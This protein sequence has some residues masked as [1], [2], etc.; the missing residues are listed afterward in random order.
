[1]KL[2]KVF[3]RELNRY[4]RVKEKEG[5]DELLKEIEENIDRYINSL[6]HGSGIDGEYTVELK[7]NGNMVIYCSFHAMDGNGYYDG[8]IDYS[9]TV[10]PSLEEDFVPRITGNFGKYQDIKEYLYEVY[11]DDL[12]KETKEWLN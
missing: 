9:V 3:A 12:Y 4:S 10:V 1:M 6:S 7:K 8:W 5:C 2:Y 11:Y